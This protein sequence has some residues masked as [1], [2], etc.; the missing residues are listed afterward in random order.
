MLMFVNC[1]CVRKM[2]CISFKKLN[3]T[4]KPYASHKDS[5]CIFME[6]ADSLVL[7]RAHHCLWVDP[8]E[9]SPQDSPRS[10]L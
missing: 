5:P 3:G 6:H 2:L 8:H 4:A 7:S 10:I 1:Q 9:S